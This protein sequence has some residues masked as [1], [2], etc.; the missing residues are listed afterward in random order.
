MI[1]RAVV[2][3]PGPSVAPGRR[4]LAGSGARVASPLPTTIPA[5]ELPAMLRRVDD[6]VSAYEARPTALIMILQ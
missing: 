2:E 1:D 5:G 6:I 4:G 3:R